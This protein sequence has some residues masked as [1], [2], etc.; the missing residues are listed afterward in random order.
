VSPDVSVT[1]VGFVHVVVV[2]A[3]FHDSA[4][5]LSSPP[6]ESR[7]L[8]STAHW[9]AICRKVALVLSA[10]DLVTDIWVAMD[11]RVHNVVEEAKSSMNVEPAVNGPVQTVIQFAPVDVSGDV[12]VR[13]VGFVRILLLNASFQDSAPEPK[14]R[15]LISVVH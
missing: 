4:R 13:G 5:Y 14:N 10:A 1:K 12:F 15:V 6:P 2:A 8:R 7:A 11:R 9:E 3:S